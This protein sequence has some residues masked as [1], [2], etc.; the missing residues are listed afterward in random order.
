M[1]LSP[2]ACLIAG[3]VIGIVIT[4]ILGVIVALLH[5]GGNDK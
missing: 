1:Y 5:S 4:F 2:T 3:I